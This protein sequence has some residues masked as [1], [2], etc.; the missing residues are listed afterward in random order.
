M[1]VL[2]VPFLGNFEEVGG[3]YFRFPA[4]DFVYVAFTDFDSFR[5]VFLD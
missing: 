1:E 5:R 2:Y 4:A 3:D